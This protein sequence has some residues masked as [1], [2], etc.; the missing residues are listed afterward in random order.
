M[1]PLGRFMDRLDEIKKNV[2]KAAWS[3]RIE[4]LVSEFRH[5]A[6][7]D[8]LEDEW[9]SNFLRPVRDHIRARRP[10]GK[11]DSFIELTDDVLSQLIG[12]RA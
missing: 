7:A 4:D 9:R 2:P 10:K 1:S 3:G 5:Q 8:E 11:H 12:S 6:G